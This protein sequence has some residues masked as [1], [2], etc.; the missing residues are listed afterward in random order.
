MLLCTA[1]RL[2]RAEQH[3][4]RLIAQAQLGIIVGAALLAVVARAILPQ[5][6]HETQVQDVGEAKLPQGQRQ[7]KHA[8]HRPV[9]SFVAEHTNGHADAG[10]E[11]QGQ[12]LSHGLNPVAPLGVLHHRRQVLD[13]QA[14]VI[15]GLAALRAVR[16]VE[17]PHVRAGQR[18][19]WLPG[20]FQPGNLHHD[21]RQSKWVIS[22]FLAPLPQERLAK[23]T[24]QPEAARGASHQ[25]H[26]PWA[27][28]G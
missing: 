15:A 12:S 10:R 18:W 20:R 9:A 26:P 27:W 4:S 21:V 13:V 5:L 7:E 8:A 6:R 22:G 23:H 11:A 28:G 2:Q 17:A 14:D 16:V 19:A 25:A 3:A 1:P 24:Q